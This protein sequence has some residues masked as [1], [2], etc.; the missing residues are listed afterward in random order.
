MHRQETPLVGGVSQNMLGSC[1]CETFSL[2]GL[3]AQRIIRTHIGH[4][5]LAAMASLSDYAPCR[6]G[7]IASW[8]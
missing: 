2:T 3:R 6:L 4:P 1:S 5:A 8:E 7:R